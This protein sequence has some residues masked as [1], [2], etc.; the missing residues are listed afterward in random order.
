MTAKS[1]RYSRDHLS[2]ALSWIERNVPDGVPLVARALADTDIVTAAVNAPPRGYRE[3][4]LKCGRWTDGGLC[5][6]CFYGGSDH[7]DVRAETA[8][9]IEGNPDWTPP[10]AS[11]PLPTTGLATAGTEERC[12]HGAPINDDCRACEDEDLAIPD[13]QPGA[14]QPYCRQYKAP[15][16]AAAP[17][18][19]PSDTDSRGGTT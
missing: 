11:S 7:A 16:E 8:G 3:C 15:T 5:W 10:V 12:K 18:P 14:H 2:E 19:T 13:C 1:T 9:E 17:P 4:A 6:R